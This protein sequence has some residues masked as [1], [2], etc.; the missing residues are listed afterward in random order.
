[1]RCGLGLV[2][3]GNS[4]QRGEERRGEERRGDRERERESRMQG[5]TSTIQVMPSVIVAMKSFLGRY[6]GNDG[7]EGVTAEI[8]KCAKCDS[9]KA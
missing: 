7:E 3:L 9:C 5:V 6:L 4:L 1:V 2:H 8:N